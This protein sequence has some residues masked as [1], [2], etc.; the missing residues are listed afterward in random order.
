MGAAIP[1]IVQSPILELERPDPA[2][3]FWRSVAPVPQDFNPR[4]ICPATGLRFYSIPGGD[5]RLA[6]PG[7]TSILSAVAEESEKARLRKWHEGEVAAGR[8][9]KAGAE[10]GTRAHFLLEQYI[11]TGVLEPAEHTSE[12]LEAWDY[13]RGMERHLRSYDQFIWSEGPLR[14]GWEH[15]YSDADQNGER[16]PRVWSTQWGVAGTPDVLARHRRGLLILS[17]FKTATRPYYRPDGGA[18]VPTFHQIGYLK[19]K[20]T[21]RQLCLYRLAIK[22]TLGLHVD[23]LQIIVGLPKP[24]VAQMFYVSEIEMA[25]ETE[26]AKQYCVRFW[27]RFGAGEFAAA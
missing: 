11:R 10:R 2:G 17:D 14:A 19:Y 25:Q 18:K 3:G 6:V 26:R 5:G 21:V 4:F 16:L 1:P 24:G 15:C 12:W 9:P 27:E 22:E 20:K 7:V 23:R 13:A 8:N